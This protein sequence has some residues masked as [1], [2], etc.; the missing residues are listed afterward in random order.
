MPG[1][2]ARVSRLLPGRLEPQAVLGGADEAYSVDTGR[3]VENIKS[4]AD[5]PSH[6]LP[7][8]IVHAWKLVGRSRPSLEWR[9][10]PRRRIS[11]TRPFGK[12]VSSNCLRNVDQWPV[13]NTLEAALEPWGSSSLGMKQEHQKDL[14][15]RRITRCKVDTH[16]NTEL[17]SSF[18]MQEMPDRCPREYALCAETDPAHACGAHSTCLHREWWLQIAS[19]CGR[20]SV[21]QIWPHGLAFAGED[22]G[23]KR[24]GVCIRARDEGSAVCVAMYSVCGNSPAAEAPASAR[25]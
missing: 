1:Y 24:G 8:C 19:L 14:R 18:C 7:R 11:R 15:L 16:R 12:T 20:A 23:Q 10:R 21:G 13:G 9:P 5:I 6:T 25:S 3:S 2:L 22:K 17:G 4:L